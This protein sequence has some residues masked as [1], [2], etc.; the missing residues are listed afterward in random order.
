MTKIN[1]T[2]TE[3]LGIDGAVCT[4]IFDTGS[5][6]VL[7][8]G[9]SGVNLDVAAAGSTEVVRAMLKTIKT[10]NLKEKINDFLIT[11]TTQHHIIRPQSFGHL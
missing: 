4:A 5:G 11:L 6:M 7:A 8:K 10:L 9:G 1:E 2:I 3:L